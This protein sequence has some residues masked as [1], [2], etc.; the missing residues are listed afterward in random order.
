MTNSCPM[1]LLPT[2]FRLSPSPF[3]ACTQS[4]S[5]PTPCSSKNCLRMNLA[6]L[7][8]KA[9]ITALGILFFFLIDQIASVTETQ[10]EFSDF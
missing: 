9:E 6:S 2:T 3:S 7:K 4:C 1:N 5:G 8:C 10:Y